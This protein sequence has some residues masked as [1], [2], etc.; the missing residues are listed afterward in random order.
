MFPLRRY[1]HQGFPKIQ[2]VPCAYFIFLRYRVPRQS[3]GSLPVNSTPRFDR[4]PVPPEDLLSLPYSL[5][6]DLSID[7]TRASWGRFSGLFWEV[8]TASWERTLKEAYLLCAVVCGVLSS[9]FSSTGGRYLVSVF[10][11]ISIDSPKRLR[12]GEGRAFF[13]RGLSLQWLVLQAL[14]GLVFFGILES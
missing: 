13:V 9:V 6:L 11:E 7:T 2:T 8:P 10:F 12:F 14:R 5:C 4:V 3:S 1:R